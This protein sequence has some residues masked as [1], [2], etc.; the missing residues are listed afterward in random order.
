VGDLIR[1]VDWRGSAPDSREIGTVLRLSQY[2]TSHK[3]KYGVTESLSEILWNDG[4]IGWILTDRL[5]VIGEED[6][7]WKD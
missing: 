3:M 6:E 2:K 5:T 7:G 4:E 1:I